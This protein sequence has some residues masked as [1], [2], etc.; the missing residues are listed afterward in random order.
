M[1]DT[2]GGGIATGQTPTL[3]ERAGMVS[4][5]STCRE[6]LF[7]YNILRLLYL[8]LSSPPLTGN[9]WLANYSTRAL[10]SSCC[11]RRLD[12]LAVFCR[13]CQAFACL[14]SAVPLPCASAEPRNYRG[15]V[16]H[17]P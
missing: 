8:Q 4:C 10:P 2:R 6:R 14:N 12:L 9:G 3:L 5:V 1:A 15:R 17:A 7:V 16:N 11:R 13:V